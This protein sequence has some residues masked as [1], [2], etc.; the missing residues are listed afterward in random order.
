MKYHH[1]VLELQAKIKHRNKEKQAQAAEESRAREVKR[2]QEGLVGL[3][4]FYYDFVV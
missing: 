2:R 1:Q 3:F 4:V